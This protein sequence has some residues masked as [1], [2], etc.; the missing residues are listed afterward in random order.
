MFDIIRKQVLYE[1]PKKEIV[2]NRKVFYELKRREK[3]SVDKWLQRVQKCIECCDF[4]EFM[5]FLV[6]DRFVCG[7]DNTE[8]EI[9]L[10]TAA[11]SLKQ[12]LEHF[13]DQNESNHSSGKPK[14]NVS[15]PIP[16]DSESVSILK[17]FA[18]YLKR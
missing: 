3:E 1:A 14:Q 16:M 8:M 2:K 9:I 13:L 11:W 4:P 10:K 6:I 12:L 17:I 5:E 18:M 7:L 15:T